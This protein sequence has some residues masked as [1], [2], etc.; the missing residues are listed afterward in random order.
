MDPLKDKNALSPKQPVTPAAQKAAASQQRPTASV[1]STASTTTPSAPQTPTKPT[2]P[3][4][5]RLTGTISCPVAT[6]NTEL[7]LKNRRVAITKHGYGPVYPLNPNVKFWEDK[8]VKWDAASVEDAK[9]SKCGNCAHFKNDPKTEKC[10]EIGKAKAAVQESE[11]NVPD[12]TYDKT[13]AGKKGYCALHK[14]VCDGSRV[15]DK[16]SSKVKR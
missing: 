5:D 6:Q 7:H 13:D 10:I 15:C 3:G 11:V 16:W 12:V 14:F 4:G 2:Q 8:V 9:T 1:A